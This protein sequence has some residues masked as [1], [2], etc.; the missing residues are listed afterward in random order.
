MGGMTI[1]KKLMFGL[2]AVWFAAVCL[3]A[4]YLYTAAD[5]GGDLRTATDLTAKKLFLASELGGHINKMRSGQRGVLLFSI[6]KNAE[7][8]RQNKQEFETQSA[9]VEAALS[10]LKNMI[11]LEAARKDLE[12]IETELPNLRSEFEQV[13]S[14]AMEGDSNKALQLNQE[15]SVKTFDTLEAAAASLVDVQNQLLR[16][17]SEQGR[18]EASRARWTASALLLVAIA[19]APFT[20]LAV[21]RTTRQLRNVAARLSEGAEQITSAASQV[22]ASSQTLAQGA[23]EQAS[24]LEETSSSSEEITSMTR[25]NAENS[26]AAAVV[27]DEGAQRVT[28]GNRTLTE[29]VQSMQEITRSSDKISKIIK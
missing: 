13:A 11:H 19:I 4:G 10:Q 29:M 28:E 12:V 22:A 1:G 20:L 21:I 16:Q 2:G 23:S 14:A 17:A 9:A 7:Q 18:Q 5:L 24:A 15:L 3:G 27:M 26:Q 6:Q 8:A 25:K